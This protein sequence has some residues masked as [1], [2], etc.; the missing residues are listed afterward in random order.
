MSRARKLSRRQALARTVAAATGAVSVPY[1]IPASALG[2]AGRAAPSNRITVGMIGMGR[3][4]LA[5][6]LPFFLSQDD[7]EVVALCDVDRWRLAVTPERTASYYGEQRNRCPNIPDCPRH[8]D[9]V[10]CSIARTST[11]S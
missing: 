6:N 5:Y 7:C 9:F 2:R 10:K 11:R 8:V 3:Q 4:V 1:L